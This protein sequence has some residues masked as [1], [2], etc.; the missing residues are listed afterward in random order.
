VRSINSAWLK[1]GVTIEIEGK[2]L[3]FPFIAATRSLND[4]AKALDHMA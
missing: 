3:S 1:D 4:K 2:K